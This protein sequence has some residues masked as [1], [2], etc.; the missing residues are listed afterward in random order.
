MT[1]VGDELAGKIQLIMSLAPSLRSRAATVRSSPFQVALRR[2]LDLDRAEEELVMIIKVCE[3][4]L[5]A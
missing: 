3:E 1:V 5:S 2:Q 4:V